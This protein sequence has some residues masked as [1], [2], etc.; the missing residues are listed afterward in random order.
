[1]LALEISVPE[2]VEIFIKDGLYDVCAD[3][4]NKPVYA[5]TSTAFATVTSDS[6]ISVTTTAANK[7]TV[8]E[9]VVLVTVTKI[10]TATTTNFFY[11]ETGVRSQIPRIEQILMMCFESQMTSFHS[12]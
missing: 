11:T 7:K 9:G 1:M 8:T 3:F 4:L 2:V 10:L 6:V 12:A 5:T